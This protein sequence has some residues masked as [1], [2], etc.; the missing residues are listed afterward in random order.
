MA[1]LLCDQAI[2]L[3]E[4]RFEF[5]PVR[6]DLPALPVAGPLPRAAPDPSASLA[7]QCDDGLQEAFESG[8]LGRRSRFFRRDLVL[9]LQV[10]PG[11]LDDPFALLGIA[12]LPAHIERLQLA[13]RD[14]AAREVRDEPLALLA[15][16]PGQGDQ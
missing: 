12:P 2:D 5:L 4:D 16:G 6:R 14:R 7:G 11:V 10:E 3:G 9:R 15:F 13:H 8:A 1:G